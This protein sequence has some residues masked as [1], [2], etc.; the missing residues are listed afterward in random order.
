MLREGQ[1]TLFSPS[2]APTIMDTVPPAALSQAHV[3]RPKYAYPPATK[4]IVNNIAAKL[5]EDPRFYINV[6][7]LM[8]K[9]DLPPPFTVKSLVSKQPP[10][11]IT[12]S[13]KTINLQKGLNVAP[14]ARPMVEATVMTLVG[15]GQGQPPQGS[16]QPGQKRKQTDDLLA[17]DESEVE[18]EPDEEQERKALVTKMIQEGVLTADTKGHAHVGALKDTP[19]KPAAV[20]TTQGPLDQ[21]HVKEAARISDEALLA[22]DSGGST[23]DIDQEAAHLK[24]KDSET[25]ATFGEK[26]EPHALSKSQLKRM[27]K[28]QKM[29]EMEQRIESLASAPALLDA[30]QKETSTAPESSTLVA[31]SQAHM[32]SVTSKLSTLGVI[33]PPSE[34]PPPPPLSNTAAEPIVLTNLD[35][36]MATKESQDVEG[37]SDHAPKEPNENIHILNLDFKKT[38]RSDLVN[39]F[40]HYFEPKEAILGPNIFKYFTKGKL[41][42]QAFIRMPSTD[43]ATLVIDQIHGCVLHDRRIVVQY[44]MHKV[45]EKQAV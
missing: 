2:S 41:R 20:D 21:E 8:N 1:P 6:L 40:A 22:A 38:S 15:S 24:P 11:M 12:A 35:A 27:R 17:S 32:K 14:L 10:A 34:A 25:V 28:K 7:H 31:M 37:V 36:L 5:L 19:A 3:P 23:M 9:M 45:T 29:Q 26:E 30:L 42:N 18:S 39:I 43:K 44:G 16:S 4:P 13:M 33:P